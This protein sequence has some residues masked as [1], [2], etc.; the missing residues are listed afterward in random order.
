MEFLKFLT[1]YNP[2]L[3]CPNKFP[4][5]DRLYFIGSYCGKKEKILTSMGTEDKIRNLE[6]DL[7]KEK[8]KNK[9]LERLLQVYQKYIPQ[10]QLQYIK[11]TEQETNINFLQKAIRRKQQTTKF[12]SLSKKIK[13]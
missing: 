3:K 13:K 6:I 2:H 7:N 1:N 9:K 8:E 11:G 4:N 5:L 10:N 12:L